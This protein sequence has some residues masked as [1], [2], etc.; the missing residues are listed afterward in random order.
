[1]A[2]LLDI[3]LLGHFEDLFIILLIFT[4][5]YAIL[6][7][8]KPFGD[9]KGI[10]AMLSFAIAMIFIFSKDAINII[11]DTVPWIIIM[12]I[13]LM[14]VQLATVSIGAEIPLSLT[15]NIGTYLFVI[16]IIILVINIGQR[17]GQSA[18]PYLG[19]NESIDPDNVVLGGDADVGTGSFSQN[20][21][22]TLFHPKVL[23]MILVLVVS[24]FAIL[25][26]GNNPSLVL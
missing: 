8:K 18:G 3:S 5:T 1:M 22:A 26:I 15:R 25:L 23:A 14:M 13:V 12:L 9:F 7:V 10:N 4:A 11:K 16:G 19:S 2:S 20:F 6:M 17:V 21:G 24:L